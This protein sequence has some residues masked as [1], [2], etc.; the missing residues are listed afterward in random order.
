MDRNATSAIFVFADTCITL[1]FNRR[2][3]LLPLAPPRPPP[4]IGTP[5]ESAGSSPVASPGRPDPTEMGGAC[6]RAIHAIVIIFFILL[7]FL[8]RSA[9]NH[10]GLLSSDQGSIRRGCKLLFEGNIASYSIITI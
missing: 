4:C 10:P 5:S 9:A 1:N 6:L 8:G 3:M 2:W 7:N